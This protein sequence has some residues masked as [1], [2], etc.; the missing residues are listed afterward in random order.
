MRVISSYEK[1]P[2]NHIVCIRN[3]VSGVNLNG[4]SV[5][6][7]RTRWINKTASII[8]NEKTLNFEAVKGKP[9]GQIFCFKITKSVIK[10]KII[11]KKY[12]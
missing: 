10:L 11:S 12:I 6:V 5:T 7:T 3:G 9:Q 8:E 4:D 2:L 1:I